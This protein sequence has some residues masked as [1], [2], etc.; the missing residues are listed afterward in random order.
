M[1]KIIILYRLLF[2]FFESEWEDK[3]ILDQM[4]AGILRIYSALNSFM[5]A[6]L[7]GVVPKYLKFQFQTFT[8]VTRNCSRASHQQIIIIWHYNPLWVFLPSQPSLSKFFYP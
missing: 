8:S 6:G 3:K 5:H 1:G 7:L 2:M 4:V